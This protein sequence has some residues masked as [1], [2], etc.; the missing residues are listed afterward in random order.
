[1]Y[2]PALKAAVRLAEYDDILDPADVYSILAL[3]AIATK[4]YSICSK[5]CSQ[6]IRLNNFAQ[7]RYIHTGIHQV[8]IAPRP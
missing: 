1:M 8:G 4:C 6:I 7:T 2:A 5:A 3:A